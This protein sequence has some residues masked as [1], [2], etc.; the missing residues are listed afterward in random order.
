MKDNDKKILVERLERIFPKIEMY[1]GSEEFGEGDCS[2]PYT[3]NWYDFL[4]KL[5]E[6]GLK[7]TNSKET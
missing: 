3:I 6:N 7:I 4:D 5:S 1:F 2:P